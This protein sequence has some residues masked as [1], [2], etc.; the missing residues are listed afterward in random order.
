[1]V[2]MFASVSQAQTTVPG[3]TYQGTVRW[4]KAMSPITVTRPINL[5]GTLIVDAGVTVKMAGQTKISL[6]NGALSKLLINGTASEP[7]T[8]MAL[9][10]SATGPNWS[11][12]VVP[13]T[14]SSRPVIQISHA[15][16]LGLGMEANNFDFKNADF[17][18]SDT[19]VSSLAAVPT[20]YTS[21]GATTNIYSGVNTASGVFTR[22]LFI[23]Q[24][25][26]AIVTPGIAFVDCDF[27]NVKYPVVGNRINISAINY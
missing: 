13:G 23:G 7:V 2:A 18:I 1:M 4:T 6:Y 21:A 5:Y 24:T 12:F 27:E 14:R 16:L 11:G 22:C 17:Q 19:V 8:F 10:G 26:G 9:D 25:T 20:G 3:G 15:Y